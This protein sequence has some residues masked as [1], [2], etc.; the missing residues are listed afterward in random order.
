[1]PSILRLRDKTDSF[2]TN[3]APLFDLPFRLLLVGKSGVGKTNFIA[4]LLLRDEMYRKDFKPENVY[5]FS[6][7]L[8]GDAKL[9][10]II[11]ELEIPRSNLFD[12]MDDDALEAI[13]DLLQEEYQDDVMDK[14]KPKNSL[15]ILDDLSF[16][17]GMQSATKKGD[18]VHR[19]FCNGRKFLVSIIVTTQKYSQ[20]STVARENATAIV[21]GPSS[22]KQIDLMESDVNYLS[23]KKEFQQMY[24]EQTPTKHDF[25]IINFS[26]PYL[27]QN[28]EFE[29]IQG[30]SAL[31]E[32]I[33]RGKKGSGC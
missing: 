11:K 14:R 1:M 20:I 24:R 12:K 2:A 21:A 3:K 16:G 22:N 29:P 32:K 5:I 4:N 6:G 13:Y 19:L 33:A 8:N 9:E 31:P 15:I 26:V 7:S 18:Q 10:T 27:Y 30:H 23:S 28:K 17:G 25:F